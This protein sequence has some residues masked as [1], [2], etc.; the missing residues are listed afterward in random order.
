MDQVKIGKF[1][2]SSR[3]EQNLTQVQLAEKLGITDRAVSKW[4]NG[5]A[6]PDSS[7]MLELCEILHITVT[8]LLSGEVVT[9]EN[10]NE[11]MQQNLL[12][13]AK[14]KEASDKR[15][16]RM[17]IVLGVISV[18]PLVASIVLVNIISMEEWLASVIV[19]IS[20]IPLL[21]ATPFAI[22]IEQKAGYYQCRKCAHRYVP[23]YG[24]VF[25]AMHSGRTRYLK[26][27]NCHKYSW[28]KKVLTQE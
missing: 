22:K 21:I 5:K 26:C 25:A 28:Q 2:A 12:E 13:M 20:L 7:I 6:M 8:D 3:K 16:L 14:E 11:Q 4:E 17:E 18:L 24:S 1:I 19:L 23:A 27:P 10:Y 9:M 15:L